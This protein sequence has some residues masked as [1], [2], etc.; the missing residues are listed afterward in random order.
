MH[1]KICDACI[2]SEVFCNSCQSKIESGEVSKTELDVAKF[3]FGLKD[4]IKSLEDA[5]ILKVIDGHA[6]IIITE[7]GSAAK[8]VGKQGSVVKLLAKHFSKPIRVVEADNIKDFIN[9]L[10]VPASAAVNVAYANGSECYR[11]RIAKN[12]R[13][14]LPLEPDEI[15]NAVKKIFGKS[16]EILFE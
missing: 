15:R 1:S 12:Q 8:I 13:N 2:K 6:I 9:S 3:L 10:I 7:K 5:N 11:I 16:A 4:R 14:R